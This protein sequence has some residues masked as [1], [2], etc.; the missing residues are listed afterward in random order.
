MDN[1]INTVFS[2]RADEN[3]KWKQNIGKEA[4][5]NKNRLRKIE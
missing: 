3:Y 5:N 4:G 2:E 1:A